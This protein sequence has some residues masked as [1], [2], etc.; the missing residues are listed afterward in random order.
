[1]HGVLLAIKSNEQAHEREDLEGAGRD[2]TTRTHTY[3]VKPT[4]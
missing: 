1:M 4:A 2:T 3:E